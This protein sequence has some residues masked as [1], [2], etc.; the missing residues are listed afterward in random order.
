MAAIDASH[1]RRSGS[2]K[3]GVVLVAAVIGL[4]VLLFLAATLM[5]IT[6]SMTG[7]SLRQVREGQALAGA[8]AACS[9]GVVMLEQGSVTSVPYVE[10]GIQLG[11]R[12]M[13]LEIVAVDAGGA[14]A[15]DVARYEIRGTGHSGNVQRTVALGGRY[16]SFLR[17]SRFLESGGISYSQGATVSGQLYAG[18]DLSLSGY[19]VTFRDTVTVTGSVQNRPY[20]VFHQD[21]SEQAAPIQLQG[22]MD[23]SHYRAMAQQAGMYYNSGTPL[24]D[25]SVFDFNGSQPTY[26]DVPLGT[27]FNGLVFSEGDL[28]VRGV[29]EGRA[30]T[31]VAADDI[32]IKDNV[33]TGCSRSQHAVQS[34]AF[35][36]NAPAGS[37][38]VETV[39]LNSL[40]DG[41]GNTARLCVSGPSWQR[42]TMYVHEG[43]ELLGVASLERHSASPDDDSTILP[44]L[45]MDTKA[46]SYTAEVHFWSNASGDNQVWVEAASGTPVNIGL[47]A[48]DY[49]YISKYAPRVLTVD[50]ALF[51]R[52]RNWRPTDYSDG[53]DSDGSH[54]VCRG[55]WDLDE[56]W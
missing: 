28:A 18:G 56:D 1:V 21:V 2:R 45:E 3:A 15:Y 16:D 37:E 26:N 40:L 52:D 30:L 53:T 11:R 36:F 19:P 12:K 8:E 27:D 24:I 5:A 23:L 47:V 38:R 33:R 48:A 13:D 42:L 35:T 25:L 51:A 9:R 54:P 20:G 39:Q 43:G 29:L 7:H 44:H 14:D 34:P 32:L 49:V 4:I 50:A 41:I 46:H 6:R 22:S 55:V 10:A 31:L 17:Y